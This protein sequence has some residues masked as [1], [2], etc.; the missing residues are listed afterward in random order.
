MASLGL[1]GQI[2]EPKNAF[3]EVLE[4]WAMV[5]GFPKLKLIK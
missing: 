2:K 1:K 5:Q 4:G 3:P